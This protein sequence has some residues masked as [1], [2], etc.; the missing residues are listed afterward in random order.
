MIKHCVC[1][2]VQRKA[3]FSRLPHG[4]RNLQ[5]PRVD[6]WASHSYS[7]KVVLEIMK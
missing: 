7:Y 4:V 6:R 2:E 1:R 3:T 5:V